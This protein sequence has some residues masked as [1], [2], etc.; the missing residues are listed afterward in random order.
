MT[1]IKTALIFL[2]LA[3]LILCSSC[4][5]KEIQS[6]TSSSQA[7]S[8]P[9]VKE[10]AVDTSCLS[11]KKIGW[12]VGTVKED[13]RPYSAVSFNEKYK[14][15]GGR[16]IGEDNKKVYL[17]FDEGYENGYTAAIL[18]T[19]K[20][21]K[22]SAVFFVTYDYAS[23]NPDLVC[24]IIN[25]GHVLGNHSWSHPSVPTC[26]DDGAKNEIMR[27]HNY[28]LEKFNY[29]MTL[30]RFPMGEFSEKTLAVAKNCG[31]HSVFWSFAYVDW[32][33]DN[34]PE[35]QIAL[36]R[37]TEGAHNGAI[38]LLHAVSKTNTE[39]LGDFIDNVRN[40]GYTFSKYDL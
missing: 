35:K 28:V 31:Y 2:L 14:D 21:K 25:E 10:L 23:K 38:Y 20:A 1:K 32:K 11:S 9:D 13:E 15:L 19:L 40:K 8:F 24:R 5:S 29:K 22:V 27:L 3:M 30:F 7:V 33:T 18:D 26:T 34:Q 12:G 17:T 37:T 36:K 39:I 4:S 16:F 6:P